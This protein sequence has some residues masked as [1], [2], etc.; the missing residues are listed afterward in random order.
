V[1]RDNTALRR[2]VAIVLVTAA[3]GCAYL[4]LRGD[5][6][7]AAATGEL[8]LATPLWSPRR[9]PQ[10]LVDAVGAQR[11][12]S[13]LDAELGA[14][15]SC[16]V[17]TDGAGEVASRSATTAM[18]PAS[19]EK[20]LTAVAAL[21]TLG[22]DFKYQTKAVAPAAP[23]NG[24]VARLWL[25]GAGDPGL[26][27][28]EYQ[29]LIASDPETKDEVTTPLAALADSIVAA[30]VG[31]IPG[32]IQ[33]DDSRYDSQRYLPTWDDTYRTDG[34][35]GPV[36]ALT[37]NHGFSAFRPKPIPVDDPAL[38]A[39]G[40]LTRL[41]MDRGVAVG[42]SP[43]H[44]N[45]PGDAV[46]VASVQ[47]P[48]LHDVVGS[49]LRISDNLAGELMT[50]ELG[51]NVASHGTTAA[52]TRVIADKLRELGVPVDGLAL[53][54]GSGLD[55]GNR[56]SCRTLLATLGV[57]ARSEFRALW[58]GLAIAGQTGTLA[59]EL[60]GP[61]LAGK[62]R[63]K[64]GNLTGVT[65]LVALIDLGR[66]LR[67]AFVANGSFSESGG[68]AFRSRVAEIIG[69]FPDAPPA[70]ELV[71]MPS[72]PARPRVRDKE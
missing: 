19:T 71:P 29:A 28:P 40:E 64:T 46:N 16:V 10:P 37:V 33:G 39:A 35:V 22:A 45:A 11:L 60:L 17:V 25:V 70:D 42:G 55:R 14:G 6:A 69:R 15:E 61:P 48:P 32:G 23:A 47:S 54:D 43:G 13:R 66:D 5:D 57:G 12:Q 1:I 26:A 8:R 53:V 27:T 31:R 72:P 44:S 59:D 7:P 3:V 68:I 51:V 49:F 36:G 63:G 65:G 21:S 20:L 9:V 18:A 67:F 4:A 38:F 41:L 50:R 30:G 24:T 34:E 52:G 2:I 56:M 62:L 58:D